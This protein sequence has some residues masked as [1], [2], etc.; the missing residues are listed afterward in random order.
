MAKLKIISNNVRGLATRYNR[1][2]VMQYFEN[3]NCDI[4]FLQATRLINSKIYAFN[5]LWNGKA[6][7]SCF[8]SNSRG[9]SILVN[10]HLQ[11]EVL[12]EFISDQGNYIIVQ[13]KVGTE[14]YML[15]SIYGPETNRASTK[16]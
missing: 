9:T 12:K 3:M 1:E 11:H 7:H 15:G 6:Y 13:C 2:D 5:L 14:I 8:A 10:R 4:I 16:K